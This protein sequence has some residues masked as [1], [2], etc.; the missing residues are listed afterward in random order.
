MAAMSHHHHTI[1]EFQKV[2]EDEIMISSIRSHQVFN[3]VNM[4]QRS[5]TMSEHTSPIMTATAFVFAL[6]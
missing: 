5:L 2:N 3:V 1:T 6:E 4:P